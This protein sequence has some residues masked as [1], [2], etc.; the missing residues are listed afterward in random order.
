ML[1]L[2]AHHH[3]A[4]SGHRTGMRSETAAPRRPAE[5]AA[6]K[7]DHRQAFSQVNPVS[8]AWLD[9]NQRPH[10]Y[11]KSTA[12]CHEEGPPWWQSPVATVEL[13]T[14]RPMAMLHAGLDLSRH[15]L[16]VHLLDAQAV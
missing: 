14:R 7:E 3:S 5:V 16:D 6:I 10:P 4:V 8:W 13:T 9:L 12:E 15:R 1:S 2:I 11:Q